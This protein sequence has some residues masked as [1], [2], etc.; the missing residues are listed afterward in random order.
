M[1]VLLAWVTLTPTGVNDKPG[2]KLF[3]VVCINP[4]DPVGEEGDIGEVLRLGRKRA[5]ERVWL[6]SRQV[7]PFP[8]RTLNSFHTDR[9]KAFCTGLLQHIR[10]ATAMPF[11]GTGD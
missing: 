2:D 1:T 5:Q 7:R 11:S 6:T 3:D 8:T 9:T 10:E 4:D